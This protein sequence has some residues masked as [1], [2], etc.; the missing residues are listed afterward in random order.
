[1]SAARPKRRLSDTVL[2]APA[3]PSDSGIS[4]LSSTH[5]YYDSSPD[6]TSSEKSISNYNSRPQFLLFRNPSKQQRDQQ[7][8]KKR[9]RFHRLTLLVPPA[10]R[11][12]PVRIFYKTIATM[13]L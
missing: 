4:L 2:K 12:D 6:R 9:R 5:A 11:N 1:M 10:G 3:D 13:K 8:T 7:E